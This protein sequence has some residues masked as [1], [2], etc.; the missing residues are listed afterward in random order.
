MNECMEAITLLELNN[1]VKQVLKQQFNET[2]WITA[3]ITEL[4][5][6]CRK[7]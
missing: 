2:V 1:R 6:N 7:E 3:E 4:Q 5:L